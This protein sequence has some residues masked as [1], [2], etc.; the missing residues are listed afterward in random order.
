MK[1]LLLSLTCVAAL[2]ASTHRVLI[3]SGPSTQH[4]G[5]QVSGYLRQILERTGKFDVRVNEESA[6]LGLHMLAEYDAVV[7]DA[8][9]ANSAV[10]TFVRSGGGLVMTHASEECGERKIY[11]IRLV[12]TKHAVTSGIADS[13]TT[14]DSLGPS[15]ILPKGAIILAASVENSLTGGAPVAWSYT[16]GKGR[17]FRS[18]LGHTLS[19]LQETP[20][21]AMFAR[22]VE[23]AASG[24]VAAE[25]SRRPPVRTLVVTGGHGYESSFYTIFDHPELTWQHATSTT[26]AFGKDIRDRYDVVL[27]YNMTDEISDVGRQN[28]RDFVE[29][30]KGV[31]ALHHGVLSFRDWE[32]WREEVTGTR[33]IAKDKQKPGPGFLHDVELVLTS[34]ETHSITDGLAP[35][36]IVDETYAML[37]F[38]PKAKV[39]MKTDHPSSNGPVVW[40]GTHPKARVVSI[41]LGHD[42]TSYF[43]DGFR[44]LVHRGILWGAGRLR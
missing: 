8:V 35:M 17:V 40:L 44:T 6:G 4:P 1:Y 34:V 23:W 31:V 13:F 29:A 42:H 11:P 3:V 27:L 2:H 7:L 22:A 30:G 36:H 15:S 12:N 24:K 25:V 9:K 32:W 20:A 16:E 14:A 21:Q 26:E 33:P 18:T 41:Q 10:E 39:L 5:R 43:H 19:A 28:L 38:S 37:D